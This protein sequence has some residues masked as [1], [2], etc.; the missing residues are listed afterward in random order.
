MRN[1]LYL[2][3]VSG[4][5]ILVV[6][7]DALSLQVLSDVLGDEG[8]SVIATADGA[9]AMRHLREDRPCLVLL[10]LR[11]PRMDGWEFARFKNLDPSLA[12]V[13]LVLL[14][15]AHDLKKHAQEL[16]AAAFLMKP[17]TP[18]QI[19]AVVRAVLAASGARG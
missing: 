13:P 16:D 1:G 10:D 9:E 5:P 19:L 12:R 2:P 4:A 3:V 8:Y 14:S 17:F 15:G 18:E 7:D 6:E 11:M